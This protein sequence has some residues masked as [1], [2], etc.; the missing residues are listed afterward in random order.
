M[1]TVP[2]VLKNI[3]SPVRASTL[4][5][6]RPAGMNETTFLEIVMFAACG[7]K[8]GHRWRRFPLVAL[9]A[10]MTTFRAGLAFFAFLM[11]LQKSTSV[12]L[13]RCL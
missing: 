13:K 10:S 11:N 5:L 7:P 6:K 4:T 12:D 9:M 2:V 8:Y 3:K 1:S